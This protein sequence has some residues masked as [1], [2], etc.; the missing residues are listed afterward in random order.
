MAR[1]T[2][3]NSEPPHDGSRNHDKYLYGDPR[4]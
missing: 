2:R 3:V 4:R 1:S